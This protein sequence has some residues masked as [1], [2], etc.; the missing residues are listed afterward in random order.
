MKNKVKEVTSVTPLPHP[1][2]RLAVRFRDLV[3]DYLRDERHLSEK[4]ITDLLQMADAIIAR[5]KNKRRTATK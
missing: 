4:E 1:L 2:L 3:E 5:S